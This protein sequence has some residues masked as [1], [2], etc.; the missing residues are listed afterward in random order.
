MLKPVRMC[1]IDCV[2]AKDVRDK[3][4]SRLHREGAAQVDFLDDQH[5]A[6]EGVG[7]DEPLERAEKISSMLL[8]TRNLLE[9]LSPYEQAGGNFLEEMLGVEVV[10]R[11]EVGDRDSMEVES[12]AEELLSGLEGRVGEAGERLRSLEERRNKLEDLLESMKPVSTVE[13][14]T[15]YFR[16]S[17]YLH[18]V[19]GLLPA[20]GDADAILREAFG[21]EYVSETLAEHGREGVK[22]YAV[23][24]GRGEEL[25]KTLRASGF[26]ELN[27]EGDGTFKD[28]YLNRRL[29]Y[30]NLEKPLRDVEDALQKMHDSSYRRLL[31]AEELL[32]LE[33]EKATVYSNFGSTKETSYLRM[34][35]PRD[36]VDG[37]EELVDEE[38][39]G[40]YSM[41]VEEDPGDAPTLLDNPPALKPFEVFT[42][43]YSPPRYDQM[44]PTWVTAPTFVLFFGFMVGDAVYGLFI[45]ALA[46][47][48]KRKYARYSRSVADLTAILTWGGLSTIVFG[49]LTGGYMGDFLAKYVLGVEQRQLPLVLID[50][51]YK[52][53]AVLLLGVTVAV[54]LLHVILGNLLGIMDKMNRKD[55][56]GALTGNAC[57]LLIL[58]GVGLAYYGVTLPGA[59]LFGLGFIL[60]FKGS[61]FMAVMDLPGILGRI[62]SY[63]RLLALNL[64]TPGMGMAFNFLAA[65]TFGIPVVGVFI[66]AALFIGAHLII[67]LMNSLG[68]FVHALRLHYV[69]FYGTF[70]GGGGFEFQPFTERRKYTVR[71]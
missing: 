47:W 32:R 53:N 54:G 13:V 66:A 69:E 8:R 26:N 27:V 10:D 70:Y 23:P 37:V 24:A 16:T 60:L 1:R 48:L 63:A 59:G 22:A 17:K 30:E 11:M 41:D 14:P 20:D 34:W 35:V 31:V 50:P 57:W 18:T 29:E 71:R 45:T 68:S 46:L 39:R 43:L 55:W 12:G 51:L 7:R 19:V 52:S 49:A 58:A 38:S 6:E 28:V 42:R 25:M 61:G 44:D 15:E 3:V 67:L 33:E 64:T 2:V 21:G 9:A 5:L 36:K 62:V 4:V 65:L 40:C 56:T